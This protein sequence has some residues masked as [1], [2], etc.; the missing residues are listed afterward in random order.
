MSQ[1]RRVSPAEASEL[2]ASGGYLYLDVRTVPEFEAGHPRG[3]HNVPFAHAGPAGMVPN[4]DFLP[5]IEARFPRD[6]KIIVGCAAGQRSLAAAE[7]L[8][9]AGYTDVIDQR[10][11]FSG[12][13]DPFGAVTEPG[14]QR[15][16]L[17]T[18]T[19]AETGRSFAEL[20]PST[21][22]T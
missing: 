21:R 10:A 2:V 18:A 16:G 12:V 5:V 7:R 1:V 19:A 17:P 13:R 9:A 4:P 8:I 11:G 3:A 22:G 6:E 14:W 20:L 15:A